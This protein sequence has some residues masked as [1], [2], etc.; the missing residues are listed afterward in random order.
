[1][2]FDSHAHY[3]DERFLADRDEVLS[4]MQ[5]NNVGLIM[6][7]CSAVSE[8]N[9]IIE[10]VDKYPFM[11]GS[12]GVHPHEAGGMCD[13]DIDILKKYASHDKIKAI[14]EIGL[15]Y[16]YDNSPRDVQKKWFALQIELA[17]EL[18]MPIIIHDRDA[19]QDTMDILRACDANEC[20]GVFHC[21]SGS[22]EM[23]K[24]I[25]DMGLYIA[26]GGS[27][28][29]KNA[30]KPKESAKYV[31]LDRILLETD[32]PYLAPE[33]FRG[34]RN[35]SLFMYRVAEELAAIKGVT[36]EEVEKITFENAKR[37]FRID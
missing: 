34:K 21:Y 9:D 20:G 12:V 25:L 26:F 15:D 36:V 32:C 11:Y 7:A 10:M 24:E 22:A 1:M 14:G 17:K 3:N 2:L 31:P 27:L 13:K 18:D 30:Q 37:C 28:T 35:S 23:A 16:Y 4:C 29:F 33:P 5:D 6:N 19:H 8:I